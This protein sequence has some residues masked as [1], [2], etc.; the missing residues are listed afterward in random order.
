MS[1]PTISVVMPVY[2]GEK[3]LKEAIDS[4]LNQTYANFEFIIIN[5]GSTDKTEEIILSYTDSRIVYVKNKE[6]FQLVKTL[7]KGI[8]LAKGKYIA[9]MDADDISLPYRFEQQKYFLDK[10]KD[11]GIIGSC[12]EIFGDSIKSKK[13][14]VPLNSLEIKISSIFRTPFIH[15]SVMIKKEII[16]TYKLLYDEKYKDAED[17]ELWIRILRNTKGANIPKV[18]LKYRVLE[19]SIT[20]QAEKK[21]RERFNIKKSIYTK[22]LSDF[23]ILNTEE[24]HKLHYLISSNQ[25]VH[26][27][28]VKKYFD[29]LQLDINLSTKEERRMFEKILGQ[30]WIQTIKNMVLHN[31]SLI[32]SKYTY[33][34]ILYYLKRLLPQQVR[35]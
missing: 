10:Y 31:P 32:F 3:Y 7:N 11:I 16:D 12:V 28:K 6:N 21:V 1:I 22:V 24:E 19:T 23:N 27:D 33:Y 4:I 15:P 20:R 18:L 8:A 14:K 25:K 2:N 35:L 9:R 13:W 30:M 29:K 17:Y 26:I 5:D 34:G